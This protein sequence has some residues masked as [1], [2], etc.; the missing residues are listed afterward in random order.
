M[1]KVGNIFKEENMLRCLYS[2][3]CY[4]FCEGGI[5][6][7]INFTILIF[8]DLGRIDL[9]CEILGLFFAGTTFSYMTI[10]PF[11]FSLIPSLKRHKY[12]ALL[13]L[14]LVF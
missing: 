7:V 12:L 9:A 6:T 13:S 14:F 5:G 4:G 1:P 2:G 3:L 8:G 10:G 11:L